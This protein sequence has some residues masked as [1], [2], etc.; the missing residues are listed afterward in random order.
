MKL[1]NV[2][3]DHSRR[4]HGRWVYGIRVVTRRLEVNSA[5]VRE[6]CL[7]S[8]PSS[9]RSRVEQL[10]AAARVAVRTVD[11]VTLRQLTG[12]TAHQG[13]AA[14]VQPFQ[15]KDWE[16]VV[17]QAPGPLLVLDQIQDPQNLGALIRT[18]AA[19]RMAAVVIPLHGAAGITASVEKAAAGAVNDIAICRVGNVCRTLRA[20]R[21]HRYWSIGLVP[22]DGEDLFTMAIP[23]RPV[24]VLGGE[25]GI[26][27]S[28]ARVCDRRVSIRMAG[29]SESL[30]A[31]VAGALAMY[32]IV[33]RGVNGEGR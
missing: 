6:V 28:V 2:R 13:V 24:L 4:V 9:R 10:A 23:E 25:T 27:P 5:S 20:L 19:A 26:R 7:G 16:E 17:A 8:P 14:L 32:E 21:P 30:N 18:A 1:V 3:S 33:R 31:S 12:T 15:Y 22:R 11:G 29:G